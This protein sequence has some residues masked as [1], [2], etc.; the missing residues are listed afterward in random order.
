MWLLQELRAAV[1]S[2]MLHLVVVNSTLTQQT[3]Q[4]L[5]HSLN[6]PFAKAQAQPDAPFEEWRLSEQA[7][8][9]QNDVIATLEQVPCPRATAIPCFRDCPVALPCHCTLPSIP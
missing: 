4:V 1:L 7:L 6:L 9:V 3:L 8:A 5:V 2:F